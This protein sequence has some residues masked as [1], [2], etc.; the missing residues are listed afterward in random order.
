MP[1]ALPLRLAWQ[2][3]S[4]GV[5]RLCPCARPPAMTGQPTCTQHGALVLGVV[6]KHK[7]VGQGLRPSAYWLH[8]FNQDRAQP[9]GSDY[10]SGPRPVPHPGASW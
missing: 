5:L 4:D 8:S 10:A 1:R 7:L 9:A 3:A 2:R 6:P